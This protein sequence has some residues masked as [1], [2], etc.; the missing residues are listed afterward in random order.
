MERGKFDL[1]IAIALVPILGTGLVLINQLGRLMFY[2]V[3]FE[4]LELDAYKILISS[5]SMLFMGT[6]VC[7]VGATFYDPLDR[8]EFCRHSVA[9]LRVA[10]FK[11]YR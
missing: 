1:A 7:Y 9:A 2:G 6:A 11:L 5:L 10:P 3:P 8:P 4:L